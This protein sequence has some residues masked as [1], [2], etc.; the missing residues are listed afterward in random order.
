M[1]LSF[2]ASPTLGQETTTGGRDWVWN[3][4]AWNLK[5]A[6]SQHAD[7]TNWL[8]RVTAAGGTVS[9]S[10]LAAV[11]T[12]AYA[13]ETAGIRSSFTRLNLFCGNSLTSALVPLYT[14]STTGGTAVGNTTDTNVNFVSGDYSETTGLAGNGTTKYLRT[15]VTPALLPSVSSIHLSH[16]G[17][18]YG[19][20]GLTTIIGSYDS[21]NAHYEIRTTSNR[22]SLL[23][24]AGGNGYTAT[25]ESHQV[26]SRTATNAQSLYCGGAVVSSSTTAT[27]PATSTRE[28]AVF[29]LNLT[30]SFAR[31][32][33]ATL[34]FYSIGSGLTAE[35]VRQFS[36]AVLG[37]NMTMG[38]L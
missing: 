10:T 35:Q 30:G 9:A 12:F 25:A 16:S 37:F 8:T 11:S 26:A 21:G 20:G 6:R 3:G 32:T 15:G 29:C 27:T 36:V 17:R 18:A 4:S 23:A 19:S 2:P 38:R 28:F 14:S 5:T 31:F 33:P 22:E 34:W 24:G 1:P 7:A 13:I